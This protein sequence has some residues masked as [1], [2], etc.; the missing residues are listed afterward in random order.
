MGKEGIEAGRNLT[1]FVLFL[2]TI[3]T[4][5]YLYFQGIQSAEFYGWLISI[6]TSIL[7]FAYVIL[8][9]KEWGRMVRLHMEEKTTDANK[10]FALGF[11]IAMIISLAGYLV[12][13]FSPISKIMSPKFLFSQN[14]YQA[15][16]IGSTN[17]NQVLTKGFYAGFVEEFSAGII[18]MLAGGVALVWFIQLLKGRELTPKETNYTWIIGGM[19]FSGAFFWVLHNFNP[20][21]TFIMF[22]IALIFRLV[23][24]LI[25]FFIGASATVGFHLSNNLFTIPIAIIISAFFGSIQ[26]II[27]FLVLMSILV[28][29]TYYLFKP[30]GFKDI[31]EDVKSNMNKL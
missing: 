11:F 19:I 4:S 7:F 16:T 12:V 1:A 13:G 8:P 22:V 24:N 2:L 3:V 28:S 27:L 14:A 5:M 23:M 6:S 21:Y 31:I 18:M 30:G 20:T 9:S 17:F 26:G 10:K 29:G 15:L 25:I